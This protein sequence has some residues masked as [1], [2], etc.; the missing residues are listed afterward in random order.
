MYPL[1]EDLQ[2]EQ[3]EHRV[4][5]FRF[6]AKEEEGNT[7]VATIE[8]ESRDD[9]LMPE[10]MQDYRERNRPSARASGTYKDAPQEKGCNGH[11]QDVVLG[12]ICW[13]RFV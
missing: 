2:I 7:I 3:A 4:F 5:R 1:K 9:H 10:E 13:L 8:Y 11:L 6:E 12:C